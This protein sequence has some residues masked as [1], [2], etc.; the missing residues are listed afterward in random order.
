MKIDSDKVAEFW[1]R[2]AAEHPERAGMLGVMG[3]AGA[4]YRTEAE[5]AHF[6]RIVTPRPE[7]SVLDLGCGAGRWDFQLAPRVRFIRGVDVSARMIALAEAERARR[8]FINLVFEQASLLDYPP[9]E[10]YDLIYFSSVLNHLADEDVGRAV[11]RLAAA[12]HPGGRLLSRD[13]VRPAGREVREGDYPIIYRPLDQYTAPFQAAGFK[14]AYRAESFRW[15]RGEG[16]L[17]RVCPAPWQERRPGLSL[18][19]LKGLDG[20]ARL[21]AGM[22]LVRSGPDPEYRHL[23][24]LF[25]R[26]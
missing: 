5:W 23:F 4:R 25:E 22:K 8:G 1:D 13:T 14:L 26:E 15:P 24:M 6:L 21:A 9:A 7:W 18:A 3:P 12:L 11:A 17:Q 19:A 10:Q 16:L 20:L 2:Q